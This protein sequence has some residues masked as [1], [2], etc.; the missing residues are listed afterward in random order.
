M[1]QSVCFLGRPKSAGSPLYNWRNP[2]LCY[3]PTLPKSSSQVLG[4][5]E[6][7]VRYGDYTGLH[8][9]Y[10]IKGK[11][12]SLL[13]RDWLKDLPLDWAS[14]HTVAPGS[15]PHTIEELT[16]VSEGMRNL[17]ARSHLSEPLRRCQALILLSS[18]NTLCDQGCCQ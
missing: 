2:H 4:Q 3:E 7:E 5:M 10:A 18:P 17:E 11:G 12:S 16:R 9:L 8:K 14:I 6:V 15:I 13:G 1:W